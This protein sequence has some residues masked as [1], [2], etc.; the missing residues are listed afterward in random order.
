MPR[1]IYNALML[2][3]GQKITI[4]IDRLG[5][6]GEGVGRFEGCTIFVDYALPTEEV[7]IELTDCRKSFAFGILLKIITPS[8]DRITPICPVFGKC[9]G[10]QLM[11]MPY[12]KQLE[13]KRQKV[14]DAMERI[15]KMPILVKQTRPSP[16]PLHY[17]NKI[18]LPMSKE[19]KLGLYAKN[20]HDVIAIE[21]CYIHSLLG[22]KVFK[23]IQGLFKDEIEHVLIKTSAKKQES[24]VALVTKENAKVQ[25]LANKIDATGVVQTFKP[26]NNR[27]LGKEFTTL[28]GTS[29]ITDEL[30]GLVFKVSPASFFQVNPAQAENLYKEA[31]LLGNLKG[32]EVVLDAYCGVGTLALIFAQKAKKVIGVECVKE[33]IEDAK[34]SAKLN[35]ITNV[36]FIC[37]MA[38]RYIQTL[39]KIDIVILN[40][41]RKGCDPSLIEKLLSLRPTKIIY[42]SCDPATLARD[43]ALLCKSNYEAMSV[44]PFD[45]FPQTAHVEC[46][47]L[48]TLKG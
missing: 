5:V 17:R 38:E 18:Q 26:E 21:T 9:G 40:P 15:A 24:L 42:I 44:E 22:E 47:T 37:D 46:C 43:L 33:A 1:S 6:N 14:I 28:K 30:C 11:H 20:S 2:K 8:K 23:Q 32:E 16:S 36:S 10:C 19:G 3:N 34:E 41:P 13:M 45:M 27:V 29:F 25:C 7:D 4:T 12:E 35:S 48:L 31:L 39:Q